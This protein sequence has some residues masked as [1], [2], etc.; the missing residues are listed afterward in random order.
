MKNIIFIFPAIAIGLISI[1]FSVEGNKPKELNNEVINFIR[2]KNYTYSTSKSAIPVVVSKNINEYEKGRFS[3]GDKADVD[4]GKTFFS[5]EGQGE[6]YGFL[7]FVLVNDSTCLLVCNAG[8]SAIRS[9]IYYA[10]YG[11]GFKLATYHSWGRE[12]VYDTISLKELLLKKT[13][14][15]N[16][17]TANN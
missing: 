8:S 15:D 2:S 9:T 1:A 14:P 13:K 5:C 11:H 16:I 17:W 3:V 4:S 10:Q 6:F 12:L 7:N